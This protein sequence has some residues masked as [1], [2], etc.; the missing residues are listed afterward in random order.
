M[1]IIETLYNLKK[2][3]K[4]LYKNY[5]T[6]E[7]AYTSLLPDQIYIKKLYKKR[8]GKELDLKNPITYTEK[9]NWLKVYDRKPLYTVMADKYE[10]RKYIAEKIPTIY[11]I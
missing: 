5:F 6:V 2:K 10:V 1:F 7:G 4:K 3:I 9:L 8:M 11:P